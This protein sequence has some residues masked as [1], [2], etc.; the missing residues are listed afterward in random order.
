MFKKLVKIIAGIKCEADRWE[1]WAAIDRAFD[2]E[3]ISFEDHELLYNLADM[4]V[5]E[6]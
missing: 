1:A 5:V 6:E 2:T 3:R 4:V